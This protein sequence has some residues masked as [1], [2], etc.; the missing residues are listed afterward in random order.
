MKLPYLLTGEQTGSTTIS[1]YSLSYTS[2]NSYFTGCKGILQTKSHLL[3]DSLKS[4]P[5]TAPMSFPCANTQQ[6]VG[7]TSM[8]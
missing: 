8:N 6:R 4:K 3:F 2:I 7:I 1:C 5:F